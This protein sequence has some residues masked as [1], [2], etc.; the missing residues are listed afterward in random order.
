[1]RLFASEKDEVSYPADSIVFPWEMEKIQMRVT[2]SNGKKNFL[3]DLFRSHFWGRWQLQL[4]WILSPSLGTGSKWYH[5]GP[6]VF[7][8]S[9]Y[10]I[11]NY[12]NK[13]NDRKQIECCAETN[14]RSSFSW[15]VGKNLSEEWTFK[16]NNLFLCGVTAWCWDSTVFLKKHRVWNKSGLGFTTS[17]VPGE[18]HLNFLWQTG[19][20][21]QRAVVRTAQETVCETFLDSCPAWWLRDRSHS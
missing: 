5:L 4:D 10:K 6:E 18:E 16:W 3:S 13:G 8:I 17:S 11:V 7:F 2:G 19:S 9:Q 20:H 21:H 12:N 15:V 1:M 14:K